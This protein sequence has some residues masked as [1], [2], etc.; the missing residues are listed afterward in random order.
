MFSSYDLHPYLDI[1]HWHHLF[2]LS[3]IYPEHTSFN[4]PVL[5][6]APHVLSLFIPSIIWDSKDIF[7]KLHWLVILFFFKHSSELRTPALP[8]STLFCGN[9]CV[10]DHMPVGTLTCV[11]TFGST[12]VIFSYGSPHFLRQGLSM[13]S[14]LLGLPLQ[15]SSLPHGGSVG[16]VAH[17]NR[18]CVSLLSIAIIKQ[19]PKRQLGEVRVYFSL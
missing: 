12:S 15:P 18:L 19:G 5:P 2:L 11:C 14:S 6:V 8:F 4:R 9:V 7:G 1:N 10:Y 16:R 13:T 17:G 3:L